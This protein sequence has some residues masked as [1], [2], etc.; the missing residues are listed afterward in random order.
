MLIAGLSKACGLSRDTI[1]FYEKHG[2]IAVGKRERRYNNYKEYSEET[3]KRLLSIKQLRGF[4]FTLNEI[5]DILDMLEVNKANCK[6]VADKIDE[7]VLLINQKIKEFKTVR[8]QLLDGK[9][10]CEDERAF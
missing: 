7:R 2:L 9:Q 6:N 3:L 10:N 1:R 8:K 5:S 4:G